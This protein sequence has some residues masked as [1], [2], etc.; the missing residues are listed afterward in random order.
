[1]ARTGRRRSV[2]I[3]PSNREVKIDYRALASQQP[4]R[5]W[6]PEK[7]RLDQKADSVLGCLNLINVISDDQHEAGQRYARI[8]GQYQASIGTPTALSGNGKGYICK[9][10]HCMRPPAGVETICECRRRKEHYDAAFAAV[11]E[12]GQKAAK[13]VAR[14]AVWNEPYPRGQLGD[15]KRGLSALAKHFGI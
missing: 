6:L 5:R 1:M 13:V 12:G 11:I 7:V 9:P 2:R 8:V 10:M 3:H 15:L 4:H 14:V